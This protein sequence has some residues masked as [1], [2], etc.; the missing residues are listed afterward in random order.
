MVEVEFGNP[1]QKIRKVAAEWQSD[2]IVLGVR[3]AKVTVAHL[4]EGTGYQVVRQ[5]PCAVLT[6]RAKRA[7]RT[8]L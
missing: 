7:V 4:A 6:I 1:A 2:L 5:S 3:R 8:R